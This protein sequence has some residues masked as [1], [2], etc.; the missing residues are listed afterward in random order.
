[1]NTPNVK[2]TAHNSRNSTPA[3]V[4][5]RAGFAVNGV[6]NAIIGAIAIGIAVSGGGSADQSGAFAAIAANPAGLVLL[7]V[8]AIALAALGLWYLLGSFLENDRD[9]K[10]RALKIAIGVGKGVAYLA[11]AVGAAGFAVGSGSDS[12]GQAT[13]FTAQLL[14]TPGG[15][16]VVVA[17]GL[18]VCGIGGYMVWKG[19][20]RGFEEDLAV[21]GGRTGKVVLGAGVL[22]YV[23]RGIALFVVGVLFIV[24]S[25][26]ADPSKA[27]GLDGA[28]KALADLPFGK[29]ILVVVGLGFIAYGVYSVLRARFAK[30]G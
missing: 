29:V 13:S 2:Q 10:G 27:S 11:L 12:A 1:M 6:V 19:L 20:S 18:L 24:A 30:L 21:P 5:A 9:T 16:I 17:V 28:L 15:V 23:A 26:T 4:L 25:V 3:R 7:W 22:G 8:I 14:A